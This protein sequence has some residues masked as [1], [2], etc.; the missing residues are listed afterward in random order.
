MDAGLDPVKIIFSE[1]HEGRKFIV[2]QLQPDAY[3]DGT[4]YSIVIFALRA[5]W[6][7]NLSLLLI[8]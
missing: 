1:T 6:C 2:R 7:L 3:I 5:Y 4:T 8:R